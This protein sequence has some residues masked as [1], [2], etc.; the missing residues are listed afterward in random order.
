MNS[1]K[2]SLIFEKALSFDDIE[3]S[4]LNL[5]NKSKQEQ[6]RIIN[7]FKNKNVFYYDY[8][9][10]YTLLSDHNKIHIQPESLMNGISFGLGFNQK[11]NNLINPDEPLLIGNAIYDLKLEGNNIENVEIVFLSDKEYVIPFKKINNKWVLKT[12]TKKTPLLLNCIS[13][14]KFHLNVEIKKN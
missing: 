4:E 7:I 14:V 2:L 1:N 8:K 6:L 3:K 11:S 12:F 13:W 5:E 9:N 10:Y